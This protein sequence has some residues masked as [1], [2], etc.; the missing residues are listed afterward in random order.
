M[1]KNKVQ[2]EIQARDETE[3]SERIIGYLVDFIYDRIEYQRR[4]SIRT[5]VSYCNE[6]DTSPEVLRTRIIS[7]FDS[8]KFSEKLANMANVSPSLDAVQTTLEQIEGFDDVERLYWETRR[9]LDER[10]RPDWAAINLFSVL[11][12]EKSASDSALRLLH[13]MVQSL[14]EDP[15]V[16]DTAL[17]TFLIGYLSRLSQLD[18]LYGTDI[19]A[20][21]LPR[22]V[23]ALY[24][25]YGVEYASLI[26]ELSVPD[27]IRDILT[28]TVIVK[29]IKEVNDAAEYSRID[30]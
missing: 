22:V 23:G 1:A 29:Q 26:Q 15:Q 2:K 24:D 3:L 25:T 18:D 27:N 6:E 19:S 17:R 10:F 21:I 11:Y 12:R 28:L 14:R 4:E 16:D 30:R 20:E 9:L 5:M 8:S 13:K 7:Y